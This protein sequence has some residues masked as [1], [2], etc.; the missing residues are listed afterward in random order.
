MLQRRDTLDVLELPIHGSGVEC[1]LLIPVFDNGLLA[2]FGSFLSV[3][4]ECLLPLDFVSLG[5]FL[6]NDHLGEGFLR[7]DPLEELFLREFRVCI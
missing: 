4:L 6:S 1:L 2:L 7:L 5:H 3:I